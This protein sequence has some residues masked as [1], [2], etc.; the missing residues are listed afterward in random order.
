MTARLV[1]LAA[2]E[3]GDDEYAAFGVLLGR[4]AEDVP[5]AGSGD[6]YDPLRFPVVGL[7]AHH[8]VLAKAFLRFNNQ[9]LFDGVLPARL[10]ELAILR[11][12]AVRRSPYEWAEH[13]RI[14][15]D[16]GLTT[17]EID[18][19]GRGADGF[20][21]TDR[22]VLEAADELLA[23]HRLNDLWDRLVDELGKHSA[24]ELIFVVGT[25]SMLATA[26][27]TWGLP[28]APDAHPLPP[29]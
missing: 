1:P 8:P 15:R 13:V 26:F 2:D 19:A 17:D 24:I 11:V 6:D 22:L 3:W 28:A 23:Q 29:A 4:R 16:A 20:T 7:L 12:A 14:A 21:G 5:R 25:Y 27:E 9:Q 18:A 10:R